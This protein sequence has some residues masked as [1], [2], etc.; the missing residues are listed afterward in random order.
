[1]GFACPSLCQ[2]DFVEGRERT[3]EPGIHLGCDCCDRAASP[4]FP[5][6]SSTNVAISF[7]DPFH[8]IVD[9]S[10]Q[11]VRQLFAFPHLP[12]AHA[13]Q[14]LSSPAVPS[15]RNSERRRCLQFAF[16]SA[17]SHS[18]FRTDQTAHAD[19]PLKVSAAC[20]VKLPAAIPMNLLNTALLRAARYAAQFLPARLLLRAKSVDGR[21]HMQNFQ[22]HVTRGR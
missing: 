17:T 9:G 14:R 16:N 8:W 12:H 1:M 13:Q 19:T 15:T 2:F 20:A 21:G 5:R 22:Q 18:E 4:P 3:V 11:I 7:C 6:F 10:D